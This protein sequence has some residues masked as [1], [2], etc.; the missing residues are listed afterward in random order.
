MTTSYSTLECSS[1]N[2]TMFT[3]S[4]SEDKFVIAHFQNPVLH[5]YVRKVN[6]SF[7]IQRQLVALT[8]NPSIYHELT[9]LRRHNCGNKPDDKRVK[10]YTLFF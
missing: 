5:V 4:L 1:E 10:I 8:I 6:I 2:I 7:Y 9:K 3:E